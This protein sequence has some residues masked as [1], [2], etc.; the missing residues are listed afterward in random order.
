MIAI[1]KMCYTSKLRYEN[2]AQKMAYAVITLLLCV[3]SQSWGVIAITFCV[4]TYLIVYKSGVSIPRFWYYLKIPMVFIFL[5]TISIIINFSKEPF[6]AFAIAVGQ[7]YITCSKES[8]LFAAKLMCTALVSVTNLYF[9]SFT[10]PIPDIIMVMQRWRV[11][12]LF[13]EIMLLIYRYIFVL[14]EV[15]NNITV[16]QKARLGNKNYRTSLKSFGQLTGSLFIVAMK[17]SN[18]LYD[19]MES[20]AYDGRIRVLCENQKSKRYVTVAIVGYELLLIAIML[21]ERKGGM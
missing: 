2:A 8:L 11:P 19:A 12:S 20:R 15:A 21:I 3:G 16:S 10:T 14:L 6:D 17:K 18:A 4:N 1:D 9:L 5:S 7:I 13:T